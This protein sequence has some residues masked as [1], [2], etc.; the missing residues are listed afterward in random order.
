MRTQCW[1]QTVLLAV[2]MPL[3]AGGADTIVI[4]PATDDAL[5]V[6]P[7][8]GYVQYYGT[9]EKYTK[10]YIGIVYTRWP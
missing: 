8:K 9:D 4:R 3:A 5:L 7:G 2:M 10:D 1:I 6:N